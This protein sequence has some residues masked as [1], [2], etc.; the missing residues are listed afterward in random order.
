[1]SDEQKPDYRT[2]IRFCLLKADGLYESAA[3]NGSWNDGGSSRLAD[4]VKAFEA[5]LAGEVPDS[6]RSHYDEFMRHRNPEYQN[7]L[8]LRKKFEG[9]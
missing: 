8:A 5:G 3:Q 9:R 7:Y 1:M 2:F 4:T 6:L